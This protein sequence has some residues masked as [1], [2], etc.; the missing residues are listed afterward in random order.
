MVA[1][2]DLSDDQIDGAIFLSERRVAMLGDKAGF[3]KSAQFVRACDLLGASR[4]T[5]LCPPILRVNEAAEFDKW[6]FW[7]LPVTI[8]RTGKDEV[9][10]RDRAGIVIAAYTLVAVNEKIKRALARRGA[11]V[12][13]LDESHKL[14]DPKAKATKAMFAADGIARSAERVWFV[15]ATPTPNHAGEFFVFA[16]TAGAWR[17]TYNQFVERYCRTVETP[18]GAKITGTQNEDELKALLA[19]HV[20]AR[21]KI[22]PGR[23][24]LT[25]DE[26]A[27]EGA[28]PKFE[29]VPADVLEAIEAAIAAGTWHAL[30][31]PAVA[32]VRRQIGVAKAEKIGELAATELEGGCGKMLI[33]AE[34]TAVIDALAAKLADQAVVIDGRTPQ[35]VR[36]AALS[37]FQHTPFPRV[38][39]CQRM[40]LKEGVTLTAATRVLLAEP[41]WTPDDCEQMIARAWRRGQS[42]PVRASFVYLHNSFDARVAATLAR[43]TADLA[44]ISLATLRN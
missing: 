44:K 8:L 4:I 15:T 26:V 6:S 27:I 33:F 31:G 40:A 5:I 14:K 24:P 25:V 22:D 7:G 12:L 2:V 39:I 43:K 11:D 16:R 10:P 34:H 20:L 17:G 3:G 28:L 9:P 29:G 19:P 1:R 41:P 18:F 36:E 30:D 35:R 23:A 37:D 32:T 21:H 38:L 42:Q 13:I